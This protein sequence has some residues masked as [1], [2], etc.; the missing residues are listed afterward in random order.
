MRCKYQDYLK[1]FAIDIDKMKGLYIDI[2]KMKGLL[3][4][5]V[6]LWKRKFNQI[7]ENE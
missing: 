6:I 4:Y 3:D 5:D 1:C 7:K 2:D